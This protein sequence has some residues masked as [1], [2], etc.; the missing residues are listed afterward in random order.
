MLG[1]CLS[2][3]GISDLEAKY[4]DQV[5]GQSWVGL[6]SSVLTKLAPL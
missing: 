1:N 4:P 5:G 6:Q 3:K 2:R